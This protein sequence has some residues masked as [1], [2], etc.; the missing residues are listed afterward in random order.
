MLASLL[1]KRGKMIKHTKA[2]LLGG[3]YC[4][5]VKRYAN[6]WLRKWKRKTGPLNNDPLCRKIVAVGRK[7]SVTICIHY[8]VQSGKDQI[9]LNLPQTENVCCRTTRDGVAFCVPVFIFYT[10]ASNPFG[11]VWFI[12]QQEQ[13]TFKRMRLMLEKWHIKTREPLHEECLIKSP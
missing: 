7:S 11:L 8:F 4:V 10:N 12:F 9:S 2:R 3:S 1:G 5:C 13:N 6:T